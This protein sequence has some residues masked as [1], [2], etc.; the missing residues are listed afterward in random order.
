MNNV[1]PRNW[2]NWIQRKLN[3]KLV[4]R[5]S[6]PLLVYWKWITSQFLKGNKEMCFLFANVINPQVEALRARDCWHRW[7]MLPWMPRNSFKKSPE[8]LSKLMIILQENQPSGLCPQSGYQ[9]IPL[10]QIANMF[11][12]VKF[13]LHGNM[14]NSYPWKKKL[15]AILDT[16]YWFRNVNWIWKPAQTGFCHD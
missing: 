1:F 4:N 14:S 5:S 9:C 13:S 8:L 6:N 2:K 3:S 11:K 12:L 15:E 10:C 7:G 16:F